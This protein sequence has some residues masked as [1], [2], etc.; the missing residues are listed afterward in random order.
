[1]DTYKSFAVKIV[2]TATSP[3]VVPR[4]ADV[5]AIAVSA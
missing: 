5:R 3:A 4:I 1:L 2:L